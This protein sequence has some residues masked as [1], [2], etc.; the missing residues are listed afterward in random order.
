MIKVNRIDVPK[1]LARYAK[2]WTNELLAAIEEHNQGGKKPSD[3]LW[4]KYNK[5]YVKDT[6]KEMFQ[7]KCAYCESKITHIAYPHIE[8]C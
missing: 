7:D 6:L 3:T 8:H 4:N 1:N 5:S 2:K